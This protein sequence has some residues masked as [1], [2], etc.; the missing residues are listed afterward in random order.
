MKDFLK[1]LKARIRAWLRKIGQVPGG[2]VVVES[3]KPNDG[4]ETPGI[5]N[6]TK[7]SAEPTAP[8]LPNSGEW[9]RDV[10]AIR[11]VT[12][13]LSS[14]PATSPNRRATG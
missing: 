9:R 11:R 10:A 1:V 2:P 6:P 7:P 8:G 14:G 4:G 5:E 12:T 3:D 13:R